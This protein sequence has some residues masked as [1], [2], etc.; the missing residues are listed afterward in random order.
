MKLSII[1]PVYRSETTL[2]RCLRSIIGQ[3]LADMEVLLVDDGSPDGCPQLCDEWAT[4]DSRITVIHK[5]NGGLSSA[6][7][8]GLNRAHGDYVTFIDA[9]DYIGEGTLQSVIEAMEGNCDLMEYPI[10]QHY[11]SNRQQLLTLTDC[12]FDNPEDYWLQTKAYLHTYACNK[13]YRRQ[14]FDK[15]RFPEGRVFEDAYTLPLLLRQ[16]PR[17]A[18]TARGLYY[19]TENNTGITATATG[20]ELTHLL[21]AHLQAQMPMDDCYYLHLLNIQLDVCRLTG[22]SPQLPYRHV[23]ITKEITS[24]PAKQT[25]KAFIQNLLGINSL[26]RINKIANSLRH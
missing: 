1:I 5:T 10:F 17:I 20:Q 24:R 8:A 9:D 16:Q 3:P 13:I 18:T 4:R 11:G 12:T 23:S 7:N 21:E 25:I 2:E 6:R 22:K 15:V 14:L 26:C 19:Y